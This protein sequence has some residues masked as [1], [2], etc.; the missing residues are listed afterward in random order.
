MIFIIKI[1]RFCLW[2]LGCLLINIVFRDYVLVFE[3]RRASGW[4]NWFFKKTHGCD[5]QN[6]FHFLSFCFNERTFQGY[7][8]MS[9]ILN[10]LI[11]RKNC[12]FNV[13]LLCCLWKRSY[14][15]IMWCC[16]CWCG[17]VTVIDDILCC[18]VAG[19]VSAVSSFV[20]FDDVWVIVDFDLLPA[21]LSRN[22]AL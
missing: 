10:L 12:W 2:M 7:W 6:R 1:Y 19:C 9:L 15:Y 8:S 11:F 20:K 4:L 18:V 3:S 17:V 22:I 16:N 5:L 13:W 21:V 14:V